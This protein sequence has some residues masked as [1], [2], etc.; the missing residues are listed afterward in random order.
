M[1]TSS[2]GLGRLSTPASALLAV[3][4]VGVAS[5]PAHADSIRSR[6]WHLSAMKADEMWKVSTGKG[7]TVA[8]IDSGVKAIPELEGQVLEGKSFS[9][10]SDDARIDRNGHGTTMAA[11]I[12]GTGR[13]PKGDGSFGLAPGAKILPV[14]VDLGAGKSDDIQTSRAI[15]YAAD[16]EAKIMN[17]SLGGPYDGSETR[18]A[19]KYA[20]GR[21]KLVF[22]AVGNS[23]KHGYTNYP[24]ATPGVVGVAAIGKDIK[25]TK[26][27]QIGAHVDLA[28]PGE[29]IITACTGETGLC[30]SHGSSDATALASASAALIWSKYPNW[31]NN[32][33]LRVLINT[34]GAP[35]SGAKRNDYIG[36]GVVR[37]RIAL[38]QTVDPGPA[39]EYPLPDIKAADPKAPS[40]APTPA[41]GAEKPAAAAKASD[42]GGHT[43]LWIGLGIGAAALLGAAIAV[44]AIRARRG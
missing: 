30:D 35:T 34:A 19:V 40:A 28:A 3:L 12:A 13:H 17:I 11:V 8:V 15:R 42:N 6:Q 4:L 9:T 41:A 16:S 5:A 10:Q 33:V 32:Q 25:A 37:P 24:A 39:D 26:E 20:L 23:G 1:H 36:Y 31:T 7:V 27:S 44:P 22:A 18:K 43:T 21:G 38:S 29:G 14:K 2:T